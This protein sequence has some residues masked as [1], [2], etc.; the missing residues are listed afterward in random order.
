MFNPTLLCLS[1]PHKL[2][3]FQKTYLAPQTRPEKKKK[4]NGLLF[5]QHP[6]LFLCGTYHNHNYIIIC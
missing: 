2:R 4:K 1:S 5:P 6:V 3:F